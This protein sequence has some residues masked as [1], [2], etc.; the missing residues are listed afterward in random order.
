MPG[1]AAGE[2]RRLEEGAG[3][4]SPAGRPWPAPEGEAAPDAG[5]GRAGPEGLGGWL[6]LVGLGL[7]GSPVQLGFELAKVYRPLM[8]EGVWAELTV[9]GGLIYHSGWAPLLGGEIAFNASNILAQLFLMY[10]FFTRRRIFPN[11]FIGLA[12]IRPVFIF[13]DAHLGAWVYNEAVAGLDLPVEPVFDPDTAR[14][15]ALGLIYALVWVPYMIFS[16]RV[17]N[18]FIRPWRP[19]RTAGPAAVQDA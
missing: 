14:S 15:L 8:E 11:L 1:T 17:K 9:P 13:L 3:D 12:L 7:I 10:L 18:A 19:A 16:R 5:P 6:I 4:G 2:D